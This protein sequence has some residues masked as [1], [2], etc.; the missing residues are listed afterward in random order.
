MPSGA[1][2]VSRP[3][4]PPMHSPADAWAS[5]HGCDMAV[6]EEVIEHLDPLPLQ[7]FPAAVLG[8][9]QPRIAIATT[10]NVEYNRVLKRLSG[11][12]LPTG[13]RNSDHRFE[14]CN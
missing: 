13:L 4:M 12:V 3:Q 7:Q 6:I 10:P 11:S 1:P 9:L 14:W 5:L 2:K 8:S